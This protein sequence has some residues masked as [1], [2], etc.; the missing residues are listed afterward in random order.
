MKIILVQGYKSLNEGYYEAAKMVASGNPVVVTKSLQKA[1]KLAPEASRI[2]V[3]MGSYDYS[4][5]K[6]LGAFETYQ[7]LKGFEDKTVMIDYLP[8]KV[9]R[10]QVFLPGKTTVGVIRRALNG[11]ISG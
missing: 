2:V 9:Y 8:N 11:K 5:H 6:E 7:Q 10:R 3:I 1:L 4:S